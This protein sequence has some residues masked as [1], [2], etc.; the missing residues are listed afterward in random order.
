MV[1]SQ[2]RVT[3]QPQEPTTGH[4]S[5]VGGR[6]GTRRPHD[7]PHRPMSL[8]WALDHDRLHP[9][10]RWLV[11]PL[12][13][14]LGDLAREFQEE[15]QAVEREGGSW[16]RVVGLEH[17][18]ASGQLHLVRWMLHQDPTTPTIQLAQDWRA[19]ARQHLARVRG[20]TA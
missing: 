2:P 4:D 18:R 16:G 12:S 1:K 9:A 20:A 7:Y 14:A 6:M 8:L 5:P 19:A 13:N 17:R 15:A 11:L 3:S 10:D